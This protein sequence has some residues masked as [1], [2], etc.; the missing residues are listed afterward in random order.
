VTGNVL[1]ENPSPNNETF[2]EGLQIAG[3]YFRNKAE[4]KLLLLNWLEAVCA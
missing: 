3:W 4:I 1:D 2:A